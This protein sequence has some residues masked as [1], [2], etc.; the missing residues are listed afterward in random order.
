[1]FVHLPRGRNDEGVE[2]QERRLPVVNVPF[3]RGKPVSRSFFHF[4]CLTPMEPRRG[5]TR[6]E[7]YGGR[8]RKKDRKQCKRRM[9]TTHRTRST[10]RKLLQPPP[11]FPRAASYSNL[12]ERLTPSQLPNCMLPS[13]LCPLQQLLLLFPQP[14]RRPR[15]P[16]Q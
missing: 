15:A 2:L 11:V 9:Q 16:T 5:T 1:M 13:P 14:Q 3:T 7:N 4:G 8:K 12:A 6:W 10:P